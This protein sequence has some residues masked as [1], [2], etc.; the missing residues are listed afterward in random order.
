M[1]NHCF[2][3]V[4]FY[5]DNESEIQELYDIFE[6]GTNPYVDKTVFGQI[7]PEPKWEDIP[8]TENDVKEYSFSNPRG[9]V[10]EKPVMLEDK[11]KPFRNGLRFKSTDVM[12][13]RWYNWRVHNWGTK[14]DCYDLS[15][16]ECEMPNGFEASFNTAWSPPEDIQRAIVEKY[17]NVSIS[18]FYDE[19]GMEVAGYL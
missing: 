8:L 1:P 19:P 10:G 12:D 6:S 2:N 3:R 7:I 18:W 14:W 16:D 9:E 11:D 5:S 4:S 13:D 15:I 17:P